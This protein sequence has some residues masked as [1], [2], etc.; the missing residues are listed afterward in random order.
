MNADRIGKYNIFEKDLGQSILRRRHTI[1]K[2]RYSTILI[3]IALLAASYLLFAACGNDKADSEKDADQVVAEQ[4]EE[5]SEPE[6]TEAVEDADADKQAEEDATAKEAEEKAAEE[7]A[8]EEK[9]EKEKAE[10]EKAAKEKEKKAKKNSSKS[11]K[12]SSTES[13]TKEKKKVWVEPV[14]ETRTVTLDTGTRYCCGA[15]SNGGC[16]ASWHGTKESTYNSW[17]SHWQD[18]VKR[19]TKEEEKKGNTYECDHIHDDSRWVPDT[20]TETVVVQEGYW[21]EVD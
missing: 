6:P 15:E 5:A 2:K 11:S 7:K 14:T 17:K 20:T 8:A 21:K 16:G 12:T 10:K 3:L 13:Q 9:A 18:Y 4:A 19:R 1:M